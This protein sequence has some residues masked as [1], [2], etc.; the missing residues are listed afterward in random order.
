ML[1]ATP[2][3]GTALGDEMV[4]AL[5]AISATAQLEL[6]LLWTAHRQVALT[7]LQVKPPGG[8][9]RQ[10]LDAP[11]PSSKG[12]LKVPLG[13]YPP[14]NVSIRL[15]V[16]PFE[17]VAQIAAGVREGS[18]QPVRLAPPMAKDPFAL[19]K[20]EPW[21]VSGTHTVGGGANALA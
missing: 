20:S 18:G 21:D 6:I 15:A 19:K 14:G 12:A 3:D 1:K 9:W 8:V 10:I 16:I 13:S 11:I 4:A 5:Q 7:D 2:L 17:D